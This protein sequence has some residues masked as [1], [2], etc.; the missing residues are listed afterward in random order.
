MRDRIKLG[1][2]ASWAL[3][4]QLQA[5][6]S[7]ISPDTNKRTDLILMT[8]DIIIVLVLVL[9]TETSMGSV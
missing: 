5:E 6:V 9:E 2:L 1:L 8:H 3:G 4:R 7:L